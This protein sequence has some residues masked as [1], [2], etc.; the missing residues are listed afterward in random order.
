MC[1]RFASKLSAEFVPELLKAE[2]FPNLPPSW[3]LAPSQDA[4]VVRRDLKPAPAAWTHCAGGCCRT[5][6]RT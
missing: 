4:L 5:S 1:G 3:N 6:P 2:G